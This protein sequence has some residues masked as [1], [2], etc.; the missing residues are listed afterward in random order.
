LVPLANRPTPVV[1]RAGGFAEAL[2][3]ANLGVT[4]YD[5]RRSYS[6]WLE[7][8]GLPPYRRDAYMGHGPKLM[9]ELCP[10]GD[11]TAWLADDSGTLRTYL[12]KERGG[13]QVE[14]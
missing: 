6:R 5:A 9:R 10:W 14:A 8:I 4:R 13:L 2:E 11:I 7:E 1:G 12:G 3:L